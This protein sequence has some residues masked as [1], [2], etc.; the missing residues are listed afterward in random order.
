MTS[1]LLFGSFG[2]LLLIGVPVG[3]ALAAAVWSRYSVC[4]FLTSS[5]SPRNGNRARLFPS[6]RR[7]S[8]Y[9]GR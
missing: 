7:R 4:R 9:L 6:P 8:I 5:F 1:A 2:L 3:I